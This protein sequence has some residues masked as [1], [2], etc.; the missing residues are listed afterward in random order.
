MEIP[1][2]I[3]NQTIFGVPIPF[4]RKT[5][6]IDKYHK[7]PTDSDTD[8]LCNKEETRLS[9]EELL[10][11]TLKSHYRRVE[12]PCNGGTLTRN[13]QLPGTVSQNDDGYRPHSCDSNYSSTITPPASSSE[14]LSDPFG[15]AP[16]TATLRQ[17]VVADQSSAVPFHSNNPF[18]T[19]VGP[20]NSDGEVLNQNSPG[21]VVPPTL[22]SPKT[23]E[24]NEVSPEPIYSQSEKLMASKSMQDFSSSLPS[25][26]AS[27]S[28]IPGAVDRQRL[29][30][31]TKSKTLDSIKMAAVSSGG[32]KTSTYE[33]S[34]PIKRSQTDYEVRLND[35][36][37][38]TK[39]DD[40]DTRESETLLSDQHG[41]LRK[42]D[43]GR[44][45][46]KSARSLKSPRHSD[47]KKSLAYVGDDCGG[48]L[49]NEAFSEQDTQPAPSSEKQ[50]PE[51]APA[52]AIKPYPPIS[53]KPSTDRRPPVAAKPKTLP[54]E[55]TSSSKP[56]ASNAQ[57][58]AKG[59]PV[60]AKVQS[61]SASKVL[62]PPVKDAY[63]T[64]K[65]YSSYDLATGRAELS[66]CVDSEN[67]KSALVGKEGKSKKKNKIGLGIF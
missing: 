42:K 9:D 10:D 21:A 15:A 55:E 38:D 19:E 31:I 66:I 64:H 13:S 29:S 49:T 30:K 28:T 1:A 43:K 26:S 39:D 22:P 6:R 47:S 11:K 3:Q 50:P 45:S 35:I 54:I 48:A 67:S 24:V 36:Q 16:F 7:V 14:N 33:L 17:E 12:E 61:K 63:K 52:T 37:F 62:P 32:D 40:D 53:P 20:S 5:D 65:R 44:K 59:S 2:K 60:D 18:L 57:T 23:E 56:V 4:T 25:P 27:V 58:P 8:S 51:S 34:A 41:S 46:P